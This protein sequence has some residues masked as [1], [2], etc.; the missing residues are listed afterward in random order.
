MARQ[1]GIHKYKGVIDGILHYKTK[2]GHLTRKVAEVSKAQWETAP[3]FEAMRNS[4]SVLKYVS[5]MGKLMR[6]GVRAI[7]H[8]HE[9]GDT[10]TRL[11][12]AIRNIVKLDTEGMPG[13]KRIL[14]EHAKMLNG[15][16]WDTTARVSTAIQTKYEL[17]ID[18]EH[19]LVRVK[20]P[21]LVVADALKQFAGATH[22]EF[23]LGVT[24]V[25][26]EGDR[27][28]SNSDVSG[29]LDVTERRP[30]EVLLECGIP[31]EGSV[32]V[33]GLGIQTYTVDNGNYLK[34]QTGS[35]YM[36]LDVLA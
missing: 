33:V 9:R 24:A 23:V 7:T 6:Q 14:P 13:M 10:N 30:V 22:V 35:G 4:T 34:M 19:G 2:Y 12:T 18:G 16:E 3:Q 32:I 21:E 26:Y 36:V 25:D 31:D 11:T 29:P 28:V 5:P 15:F 1:K 27:Q 8:N 17:D 20:M